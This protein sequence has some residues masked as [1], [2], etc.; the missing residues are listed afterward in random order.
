MRTAAQ[1]T[2][3][4]ITLRNFSKKKDREGQRSIYMILVKEDFIQPNPYLTKDFLL[5]TRSCVTMKGFSAFLDMKR[6]KGWARK[7]SS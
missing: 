7:I 4:Q 6:D 3:P 5:V 1:E 2:A